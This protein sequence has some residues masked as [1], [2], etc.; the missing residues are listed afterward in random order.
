MD[1][2]YFWDAVIDAQAAF[3]LVLIAI[4]LAILVFQ[5]TSKSARRGAK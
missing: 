4:F 1:F 5:N 3:A 2:N